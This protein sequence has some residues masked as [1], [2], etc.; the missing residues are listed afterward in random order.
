[1]QE[2][3][4]GPEMIPLLLLRGRSL[5][6]REYSKKELSDFSKSLRQDNFE[7]LYIMDLDGI[8]RNKP[9]LDIVQRLSDDF[10]VLYEGGPRKG[11]NIIDCIMA[12]AEIAYMNTASIE[13]FDEIKIALSYSENVGLKIDWNDKIIGDGIGDMTLEKVIEDSVKVGIKDF[14]IPV[15]VIPKISKSKLAKDVVIRAIADRPGDEMRTDVDAASIIV[16]HELMKKVT[17]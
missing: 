10:S 12:G 17:Q 7:K 1:M 2:N 14:V 5:L 16:N 11:A 4:T 15:E 6:F 13:S 9:Q 3:Q 8:E